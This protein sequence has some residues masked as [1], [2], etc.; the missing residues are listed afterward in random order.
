MEPSQFTYLILPLAII[1]AIL[2]G[3]V[4][5]LARRNEETDYEKEMKELRRSLLKGTLDRKTFLYVRD[6]LKAEDLFG[7]ESKRLDDMMKSKSL[8][9][10]TY[11]R[12]KKILELNFNERLA[13]INDKYNFDNSNSKSKKNGSFN[14]LK[15][16]NSNGLI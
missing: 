6:N 1:I 2:V 15:N 10:D 5:Y 12:M 7:E 9:S 8:D 16:H 14:K 13:K 11:V 3:I 4:F